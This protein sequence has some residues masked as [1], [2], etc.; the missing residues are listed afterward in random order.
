MIRVV[1]AGW[2]D[3]DWRLLRQPQWMAE[4]RRSPEA[5]GLPRKHFDLPEAAF[6]AVLEAW[7]RQGARASLGAAIEHL[8]RFGAVEVPRP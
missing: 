5:A 7:D 8:G 4:V 1:L 3:D 6:P 2:S